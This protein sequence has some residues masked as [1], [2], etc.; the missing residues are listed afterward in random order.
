MGSAVYKEG[1]G[2]ARNEKEEAHI[3]VQDLSIEGVRSAE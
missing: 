3:Q 1:I 2:V